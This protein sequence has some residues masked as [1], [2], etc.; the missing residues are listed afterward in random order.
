M[1]SATQCAQRARD[2]TL[3]GA[4]FVLGGDDG[5]EERRRLLYA[6]IDDLDRLPVAVRRQVLRRMALTPAV[7]PWDRSARGRTRGWRCPPPSTSTAHRGRSADGDPGR[8]RLLR[9]RPE[10]RG[11]RETRFGSSVTVG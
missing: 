10:R 3:T 8:R 1:M 9:S 2:L 6:A 5:A 4:A 7:T 11:V